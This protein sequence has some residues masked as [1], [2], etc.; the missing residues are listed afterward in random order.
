MNKQKERFSFWERR[1][2]EAYVRYSLEK[3]ESA[4]EMFINTVNRVGY[5]GLDELVKIYSNKYTRED[6]R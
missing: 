1:L 4:K 2:G 3:S 5:E 6:L